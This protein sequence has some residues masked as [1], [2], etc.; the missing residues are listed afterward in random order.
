M[1]VCPCV[2]LVE[3]CTKLVTAAMA[4]I[5]DRD[6]RIGRYVKEASDGE[7]PLWLSRN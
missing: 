4:R 2:K 6:K 1:P 3:I 5:R 7:F